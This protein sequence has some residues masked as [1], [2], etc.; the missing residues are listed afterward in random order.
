MMG[1]R[2]HDGKPPGPFDINSGVR[3][4]VEPDALAPECVDRLSSSWVP[5]ITTSP[6]DEVTIWRGSKAPL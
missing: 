5:L 6:V 2:R 3:G 4:F 1:R